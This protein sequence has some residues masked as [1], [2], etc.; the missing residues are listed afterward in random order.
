MKSSRLFAKMLIWLVLLFG[1]T[2]VATAVFS[3][4]RLSTHLHREFESK[5]EAIA[6][7]IA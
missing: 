6:N 7:S 3:A 1:I 4:H 5:G 2:T